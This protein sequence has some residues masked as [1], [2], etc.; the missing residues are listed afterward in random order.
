M[1]SGSPLVELG[2]DSSMCPVVNPIC[3]LS[4]QAE[5]ACAGRDPDLFFAD[6]RGDASL[7][8]AAKELC[9]SCPVAAACLTHAVA[10]G[11]VGIWGGT[12]TRERRRKHS[13]HPR[14]VPDWVRREIRRRRKAQP[15]VTAAQLADDFGVTHETINRICAEEVV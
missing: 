15:D 3:D 12:T 9:G 11:E 5:A 7:V 6:A 10:Y 8:A 13:M 1:R 14:R 2:S 4:W